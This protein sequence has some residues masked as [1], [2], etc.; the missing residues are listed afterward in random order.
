MPKPT[1]EQLQKYLQT[2]RPNNKERRKFESIYRKQ[3]K[4]IKSGRLKVKPVHI[5]KKKTFLQKLI[6]FFY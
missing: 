4:A 2:H 3:Q 6:N 5:T 1:P